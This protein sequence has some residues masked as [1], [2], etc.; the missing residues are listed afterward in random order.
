MC[1]HAQAPTRELAVQIH[2]E[3]KKFAKPLGIRVVAVYGGASISDQVRASEIVVIALLP[4]LPVCAPQIGA[5]RTGAE[6]VVATPGRMID[7][8]CANSGRVTNMARC[9]FVVMDE[10]DRMFDMGFAPQI[11]MI[12]DNI[13]PDR[14]AYAGAGARAR[15]GLTHNTTPPPL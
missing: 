8:L 13:R 11:M 3:T 1:T 10:A 14:Q 12:I 9:T 7:I 15:T 4:T 2:N 6:I 5:L